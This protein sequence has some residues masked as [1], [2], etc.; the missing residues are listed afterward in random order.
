MT[1]TMYMTN[2]TIETVRDVIGCA[3]LTR[4]AWVMGIHYTLKDGTIV[5]IHGV[6][7]WE[8]CQ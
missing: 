6:V 5:Y 3:N 4:L 2:G 8:V 1:L 7:R